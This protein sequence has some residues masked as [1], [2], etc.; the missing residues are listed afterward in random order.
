VIAGPVEAAALGNALVQAIALGELASLSEARGLIRD[1]FE[2]QRYEPR[3]NGGWD[4]AYAKLA[5]ML[6]ARP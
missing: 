6:A 1:S 2:L 3:A 4:E 5:G